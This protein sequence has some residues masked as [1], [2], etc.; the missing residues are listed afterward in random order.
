[1]ADD[2]IPSRQRRRQPVREFHSSVVFDKCNMTDGRNHAWCSEQ[3]CIAILLAYQQCS[4]GSRCD[5]PGC[6][7]RHDKEKKVNHNGL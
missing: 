5:I 2:W 4:L 7:S 3:Q 1:M 6:L